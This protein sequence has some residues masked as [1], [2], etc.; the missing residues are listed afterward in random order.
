MSMIRQQRPVIALLL[1][2]CMLF[3]SFACALAH[4]QSSGLQLSGLDQRLCSSSDSGNPQPA[5]PGAQAMLEC[6]ACASH[7]PVPAATGG[8]IVDLQAWRPSPPAASP[9]P[10][11]TLPTS[12]WPPASPRAPPLF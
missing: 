8:W 2:S 7:S 4:G 6:P 3:S 9:T 11:A 10:V 5:L 12:A 1:Y